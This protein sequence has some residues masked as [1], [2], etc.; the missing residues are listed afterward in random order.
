MGRLRMDQRNYP[1][2]ENMARKALSMSIGT[3][4]R[5]RQPGNWSAI[6]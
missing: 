3:T 2:A 6:H 1:Q 4:R 5:R